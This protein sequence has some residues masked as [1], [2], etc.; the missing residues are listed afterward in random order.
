MNDG[1][2]V[3]HI[4]VGSGITTAHIASLASAS[5]TTIYA[6]G[7]HSDQQRQQIVLNLERFGCRCIFT[8]V[9]CL[10]SAI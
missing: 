2:N 8:M 6:F 4:N 7:I 9:V 1:D 10:Y 5:D 3:I